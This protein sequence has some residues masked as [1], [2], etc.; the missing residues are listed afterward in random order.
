MI[1]RVPGRY[2]R[3]FPFGTGSPA[4]ISVDLGEKDVERLQQ[5]W[6]GL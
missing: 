3:V 4:T 2:R 1:A 6:L 5:L